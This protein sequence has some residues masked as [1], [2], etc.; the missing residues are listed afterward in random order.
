MVQVLEELLRN[1]S[2]LREAT[3]NIERYGIGFSSIRRSVFGDQ[4]HFR[5]RKNEIMELPLCL[6]M[7]KP[8]FLRFESACCAILSSICCDLRDV[9]IFKL[10]QSSQLI[11]KMF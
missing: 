1:K 8:F 3:M 2:F 5:C 10:R 9:N 7:K 11:I 6:S 4:H